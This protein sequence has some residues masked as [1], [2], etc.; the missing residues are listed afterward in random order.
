MCD[1]REQWKRSDSLV[2]HLK[3]VSITAVAPIVD[4]EFYW[5]L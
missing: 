5:T 4:G 3:P 2:E 1:Q